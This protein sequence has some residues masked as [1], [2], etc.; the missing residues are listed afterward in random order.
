[1][2]LDE[3]LSG[4]YE[5][6]AE[7]PELAWVTTG[8]GRLV[9]SPTVFE[10]VVK[11]ICTTN[12]AW[13]ATERM[14][15][16]L[17]EHLGEP[18][19]GAAADGPY[20]RAFP[21]PAAM[22]AADEAF[23]RDTVRAGYRGA[24]LRTL[25][26]DVAS[27]ELDLE[28]L[29]RIGRDD[30]PDDEVAERLLALPG[31]GPYAAAHVMMLL[32]R[33]SRLVLDSW[34]RPKYASLNGGRTVKDSTLERRF[35]RWAVR[36]AR[37]ARSHARLGPRHVTPGRYRDGAR[38][39]APIGIAAFAFGASYG[40]LAQTSGF[41]S[42][43]AIVMSATTFAGSAQFA[44]ASILGAAGGVVSAIVA[45]TLLN[46]R[47]APISV[48]MAPVFTGGVVRRLLE[49]QLIVDESWAVSRRADGAFDRRLLVGAGLVLYPCWI[50]GTA[51]G[52]IAGDALA[53]PAS[54]GLDAAFPALFLALLV[55][56]VRSRQALAAAVLGGAIALV[57]LPITPAGVPI[58]AASAACLIG[59]RKP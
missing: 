13:S 27:G 12:C 7:D 6:A 41:G 53:D 36:R 59:W 26:A 54:L 43:E 14:V 32:G 18:A 55:P 11:T 3:D 49:S 57:L 38:R 22:A 4:F 16:A 17:V 23:Y 33:Y 25:A 44:A 52:A 56:Q 35:R 48:S 1:M 20:G 28:E 15:G 9:R 19:A 58:V 30:L 39:V 2:R 37:L 29:G 45:A 46:A 50:T 8:A 10:E 24:Y 42:V 47:Y 31:V 51:V 34:T 21:T 40:V 5:L